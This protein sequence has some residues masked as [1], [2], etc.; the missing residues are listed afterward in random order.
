MFV[1]KSKILSTGALF[2]LVLSLLFS[3][4]VFLIQYP[5]RQ[6]GIHRG[7]D[8]RAALPEL[9]HG[10]SEPFYAIHTGG[11]TMQ[12]VLI[13]IKARTQKAV[14]VQEVLTKH[15]CNITLRLGLHEVG[16]ENCANDGLIILQ[17]KPDQQV[18]NE[19]TA[20][21][22]VLGDVDVKTVTM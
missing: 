2:G 22:N 6:L 14:K 17:V 11:K 5:G 16:G 3:A 7:R 8:L 4:Y 9:I 10:R 12:L 19:L 15:G 1:L 21:L 18:V 20:E 13:K